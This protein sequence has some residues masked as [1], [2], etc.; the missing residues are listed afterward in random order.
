MSLQYSEALLRNAIL[1]P[2]SG[3]ITLCSE[4]LPFSTEIKPSKLTNVT[5]F[6]S[7]VYMHW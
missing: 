4:I 1:Y 5:V 3:D 7:F 6:C 2:R